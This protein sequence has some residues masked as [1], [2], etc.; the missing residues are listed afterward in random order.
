MFEVDS[1]DDTVARLRAH[2]AELVGE[3]AQY[4]DQYR[5]CYL[6]GPAGIIVALAEELR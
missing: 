2:G 4:E 3:V 6:R 5:L 1:V